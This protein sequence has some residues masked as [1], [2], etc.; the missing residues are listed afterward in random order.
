MLS[1]KEGYPVAEQVSQHIGV[2]LTFHQIEAGVERD[3]RLPNSN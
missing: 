3:C 2:L 1:G